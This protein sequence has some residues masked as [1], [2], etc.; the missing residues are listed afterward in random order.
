METQGGKSTIPKVIRKPIMRTT[1]CLVFIKL[2]D[3]GR[4]NSK[5]VRITLMELLAKKTR[6]RYSDR[7]KASALALYDATGSLT[8]AARVSGIP[9]STLSDWIEGKR[10]LTNL[11]IPLMRN[12]YE[13]KPLDL[14]ARLDEIADRATGEVI[15]RLRNSKEAKNVPLPHLIRAV[16]VSVDKSQLLRGQPT[17]ITESIERR[18][19]TIVLESALHAAIDVK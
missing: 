16:E 15:G 17:S 6:R 3:V 12:G 11:D 10:C 18:D 1:R 14:I 19:L 9:D 2:R 5:I 7:E 4:I 8:E 13:L